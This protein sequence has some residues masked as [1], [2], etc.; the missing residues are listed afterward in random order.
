MTMT[1]DG[2]PSFFNHHWQPGDHGFSALVYT[3]HSQ[4][5]C[6]DS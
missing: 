2:Q 4:Y 1:G 5:L 6:P 3:F